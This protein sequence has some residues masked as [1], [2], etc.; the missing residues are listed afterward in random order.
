MMVDR[1]PERLIRDAGPAGKGAAV[2]R[3]GTVAVGAALAQ[4]PVAASLSPPGGWTGSA[5]PQAPLGAR[6]RD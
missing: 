4:A 6:A 1:T 3:P 2:P 5:G